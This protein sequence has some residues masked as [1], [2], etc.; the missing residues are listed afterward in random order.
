MLRQAARVERRGDLERGFKQKGREHEALH[1]YVGGA[2][3][4]EPQWLDPAML[5]DAM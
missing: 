1:R 2:M 4:L 5:A 3:R